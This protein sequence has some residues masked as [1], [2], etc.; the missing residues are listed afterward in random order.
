MSSL[1]LEP[2]SVSTNLTCSIS[3]AEEEAAAKMDNF[4][5]HGNF[6]FTLDNFFHAGNY[7]ELSCIPSLNVARINFVD[8]KSF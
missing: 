7:F 5:S 4:C 2:N 3:N 8:K 1:K 6:S